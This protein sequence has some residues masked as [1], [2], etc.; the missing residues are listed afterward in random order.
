MPQIK[1]A[2]GNQSWIISPLREVMQRRNIRESIE[3]YSNDNSVPLISITKGTGRDV[4]VAFAKYEGQDWGRTIQESSDAKN[5]LYI[6]GR[7]K[8]YLICHVES[9]SLKED[10]LIQTEKD[11]LT[12]ILAIAQNA[13]RRGVGNYQVETFNLN[14]NDELDEALNQLNKT[15]SVVKLT[16]S[17]LDSLPIDQKL[18]FTS[19]L[20]AYRN[21]SDSGLQ[22]AVI[23]FLLAGVFIYFGYE[24]VIPPSLKE[25]IVTSNPYGDYTSKVMTTQLASVRLAQDFNVQRLIK[26]DLVGWNLYKV[27]HHSG[28]IEYYIYQEANFG[29]TRKGLARFASEHSFQVTDKSGELA[30]QASLVKRNI[31]ESKS[32]VLLYDVEDVMNN[33]MDNMKGISQYVKMSIGKR[34]VQGDKWVSQAVVAKFESASEHDLIRLASV[35]D[36]YPN[37]YPV[38]IT[39]GVYQ[40]TDMGE[41]VGSLNLNIYGEELN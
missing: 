25:R 15:G 39:D 34:E 1:S 17:Y 8:G 14:K 40:I 19:S 35:V 23:A 37:K 2:S 13:S 26:S 4:I 24:Y 9:G 18:N 33:V 12:S 11:L 29:A 21:L 32:D 41:L 22:K 16:N 5:L 6:E 38:T 10:R 7:A 28:G 31:F 3:T 20:E 30:L 27:I 36:G